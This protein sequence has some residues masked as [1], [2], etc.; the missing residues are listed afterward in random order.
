VI[1]IS[2]TQ[3]SD[4]LSEEF[5]FDCVKKGIESQSNRNSYV[6]PRSTKSFGNNKLLADMSALIEDMN[7]FGLKHYVVNNSKFNYYIYLYDFSTKELLTVLEAEEI[8]K[9]RTAA[10]TSLVIEKLRTKAMKNLS[11]IGT[12]FQAKQQLSSI[13]NINSNFADIYVYS[14][15]EKNRN[16][17]VKSFK[18]KFP[19]IN[20]INCATE[21][22]ATIQSD[23]IITATNS[24]SPVI[25][26]EYLKNNFLIIAM[27]A[28]TP[29]F[30]E[31][32]EN[33]I[34]NCDL[35]LVDDKEQAKLE[36]G[37]L[38]NPISKGMLNWTN[39]FNL[40]ELFEHD[41]RFNKNKIFFKSLG[42]ALWDV[43]IA[44]GIYD[45]AK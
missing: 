23:V 36:S 26:R 34:Q 4:I 29:Y 22:S 41:L 38:L 27:G 10:V 45:F 43:A 5:A 7:V 32:D 12:G 44:K 30:I 31:V 18:N 42:I 13:L 11:I 3:I 20:F 2:N 14:P 33:I 9:H 17:F 37:D 24:S 6:M 8:G 19:E 28:A 35:V 1:T 21:K 16:N 40:S 15:N 39:V 25:H